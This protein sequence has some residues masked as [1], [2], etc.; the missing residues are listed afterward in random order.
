MAKKPL[1]ALMRLRTLRFVTQ[2]ELADALGV[3]VNT[4]SNWESG[5]SIPKLTP[6]Q[7]KTLLKKLEITSDE[8]PDHFGPPNK[9]TES[10]SENQ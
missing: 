3:T 6:F 9:M 7:Y 8:L 2:K 10:I 5:R 1:S 4:I